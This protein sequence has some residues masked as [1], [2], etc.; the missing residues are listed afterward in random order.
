[1]AVWRVDLNNPNGARPAALILL[2]RTRVDM[3]PLRTAVWLPREAALR[4]GNTPDHNRNM[5]LTAGH[6]GVLKFWDVKDDLPMLERKYS[7]S[8]IMCVAWLSQP[9]G[10][11]AGGDHGELRYMFISKPAEAAT[12]TSLRC[13][14]QVS[15]LSVFST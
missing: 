2:T 6:A 11:V 9:L 15:W 13:A 8:W 7:A 4:M 3:A 1:M 5:F 12:Q 10:V 14:A